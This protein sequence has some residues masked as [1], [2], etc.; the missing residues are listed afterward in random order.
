MR[1]SHTPLAHRVLMQPMMPALRHNGSAAAHRTSA[2]DEVRFSGGKSTVPV[3]KL[4]INGEFVPSRSGKTFKVYNPFNQAVIAKAAVASEED[5]NDAVQAARTAFDSGVWSDKPAQARADVL[6][7]IAKVI[8]DNAEELAQLET[9]NNGKAITEARY[10]VADSARHFEYYAELAAKQTGQ[11]MP[12]GDGSDATIQKE[13]LGVVGQIIPWNY[14]LM[15]GAW[16]MAPALAAGCTVVIKAAEE[17][18]LSLLKLA[19]LLKENFSKDEL[20]PGVINILTGPGVPTGQALANHP[21]IDRFS[22]TGSTQVGGLIA[23]AAAA[24]VNGPKPVNLEMG[25]KSPLI[26]FKDADL[27]QAADAAVFGFNV[28]GGQVCSATSRIVVDAS[29]HDAFVEKLVERMKHI[30]MGEG[31]D[32]NVN[33]GP[34]VSKAQKKRVLGFIQ[35]GLQEGG[36]LVVGGKAPSDP[37]LAQGNFVEPTL[38]THVDPKSTIAQ[39]EIFGPVAVVLPF[40]SEDEALALANGTK[41]G[42]AASIWT[43]D[44]NRAKRVSKKVQAGVVWVNN[45]QPANAEFPWQGWK[46]SGNGFGRGDSLDSYQKTKTVTFTPNPFGAWFQP[47]PTAGGDQ[48]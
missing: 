38:F 29:I 6:R 14:P 36:K 44:L 9:K 35:K 31:T 25:G 18:P 8:R 20:P 40:K 21:D 33:L 34:L 7:K 1:I 39:E 48:K 24:N 43:N 42:L 47:L 19:S 10:D 22:F 4:F 13:P 15:M 2:L 23:K 16:K 32:P 5:V 12:L 45:N 41:Y 27:D 17:T 3:E 26:V 11:V 37:K 28:N 30:R 46:Q